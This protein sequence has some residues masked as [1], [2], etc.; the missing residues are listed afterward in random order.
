[1]SAQSS[2][3]SGRSLQ[4]GLPGPEEFTV[5]IQKN[6]LKKYNVMRFAAN[7]GVDMSTWREANMERETSTMDIYKDETMPEYGEGSEY[8][9]K[10]REEARQKKYGINKTKLK[11]EDQPWLLKI[12]GKGGKRFVGRKEGG[13]NEASSY[14]VF[15]QTGNKTFEACPVESWYNFTPQ[16]KYRYLN[17]E[18]A[19]AEFEKR[20]KVLNYFNIM[21][22]KRLENKE[23]GETE[24]E[25]EKNVSARDDLKVREGDDSDSDLGGFSDDS[26]NEAEGKKEKAKTAKKKKDTKVQKKKKKK[27]K[28]SDDEALEDSDEGD[29]D[30]RE[31]DYM[32]DEDESASE[33][34]V[35][36]SK[37][38]GTDLK[39][40]DQEMEMSSSEEEEEGE[41]EKEGETADGEKTAEDKPAKKEESDSSSSE[42]S[43]VDLESSALFMQDKKGGK[44]HGKGSG[45]GRSK[46]SLKPLGGK[47]GSKGDSRS[48]SSSSSRASTPA[49]DGGIGSTLAA[50]AKKLEQQKGTKRAGEG[51][52]PLPKKARHS[53]SHEGSGSGSGTPTSELGLTEESVRRY[54]MRKPMTAK[55][56]L[57]K[58][59]TGKTGLNR[60]QTVAKV[61]EILKKLN[62]E[63]KTING[64][65]HLWL[66]S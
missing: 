61:T 37:T 15:R 25:T 60:D 13:I 29:Y 49:P 30:G 19:E 47:V 28:G 55:D 39:G 50:A 6:P 31:V 66:K 51:D 21:M 23:E 36:K 11:L 42:D 63:K 5:R 8:G 9:R 64:K 62:P 52:S 41:G 27:Q 35:D 26:D 43:D 4:G 58:F 24:G 2:S 53:R 14:F 20:H 59:P 48:G 56:L 10:W 34:E 12:G 46:K 16:I 1:M 57:K 18:E 17:E 45:K 7:S 33:E 54:L 3:S 65:I 32:S 38:D 44:T 22:K 40:V